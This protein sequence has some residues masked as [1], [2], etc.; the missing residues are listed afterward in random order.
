[1]KVA[2]MMCALFL[3]GGL[4]SFAFARTQQSDD[5]ASASDDD[6]N[7]AEVSDL[8]ETILGELQRRGVALA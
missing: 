7:P 8:V 1:M 3:A 5:S 6:V 2:K 4:G